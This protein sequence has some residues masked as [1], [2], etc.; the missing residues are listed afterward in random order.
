MRAGDEAPETRWR[1]SWLVDSHEQGSVWGRF[2]LT[3]LETDPD[4]VA[5][6]LK[7]ALRDPTGILRPRD[8]TEDPNEK[9]LR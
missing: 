8:L 2:A 4:A 6:L 3:L 5:E 7:L 1:Q 9:L